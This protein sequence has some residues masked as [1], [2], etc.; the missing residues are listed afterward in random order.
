MAE[1]KFK[2]QVTRTFRWYVKGEGHSV[3]DF[4]AAVKRTIEEIQK[5]PE[6]PNMAGWNEPQ[7]TDVEDDPYCGYIQV[8]CIEAIEDDGNG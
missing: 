7:I 3:A 2:A 8:E 5:P 4:E 6:S 1:Q